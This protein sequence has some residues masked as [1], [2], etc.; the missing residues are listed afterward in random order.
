L[1][2]TDISSKILQARERLYKGSL[3]LKTATSLLRN[4]LT[5]LF[6]FWHE[7]LGQT[8]ASLEATLTDINARLVNILVT[9][10]L[11]R[12][13]SQKIANN[14]ISE[15]PQIMKDLE[16]DAKAIFSGDPAAQSLD[17][18]VLT[19]PGFYAISIYR[20]ANLLFKFQVPIIPRI[21]SEY[22]HSKTGI[23][24]H[25]GASIASGFCMDHGTGIVI[26]ETS[27]VH[28]NVKI[29]HGVTLGGLS[30]TKNM[31]GKKRHP[32]IEENVVIYAGTTILGGDTIVGRDSI[33]GGNVWLTSSVAPN[34]KV[35][36][37]K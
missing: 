25:P 12:E 20:L 6:P 4:C 29:Y 28:K 13:D 30:V 17:E 22:A 18:V 19:Y 5:A 9:V 27:I 1:D 31:A 7:Q 14:F 36:S 11:T 35:Y 8:Q 2:N 33:I 26:G 10:N 23:D 34:S 15:L 3:K 32:T 24:I 21:W 37:N 16:E